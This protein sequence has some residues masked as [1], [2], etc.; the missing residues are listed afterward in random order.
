MFRV[1]AAHLRDRALRLPCAARPARRLRHLDEH[2]GAAANGSWWR[3]GVDRPIARCFPLINR[4]RFPN[5]SV[6]VS[7]RRATGQQKT[8]VERNGINCS[9]ATKRTRVRVDECR[10][11]QGGCEA[12][13]CGCDV[14]GVL[15]DVAALVGA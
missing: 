3:R 4:I 11:E 8:V 10:G 14:S 1:N 6:R 2:V 13:G 15:R 12:R 5:I 7:R 9:T